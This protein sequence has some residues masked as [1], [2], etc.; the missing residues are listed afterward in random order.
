MSIS[1]PP[2]LYGEIG[3][4]RD[5]VKEKSSRAEVRRWQGH[6]RPGCFRLQGL[7]E[8]GRAMF[9]FSSS[10]PPHS[11]PSPPLP[12]SSHTDCISVPFYLVVVCG[13]FLQR[14]SHAFVL[15]IFFGI[16][17]RYPVGILLAFTSLQG[18][19]FHKPVVGTGEFETLGGGAFFD[20]GGRL[21][22]FCFVFFS[23]RTFLSLG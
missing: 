17:T 7:K 21:S 19:G 2:S 18:I 5:G 11:S 13:L 4:K 20:G 15:G 6:F 16:S 12:P 10:P 14:F 1:C 3:R 23:V 22:V 9:S 8:G